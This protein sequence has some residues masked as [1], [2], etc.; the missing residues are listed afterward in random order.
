VGPAPPANV[1]AGIGDTELII[2]WDVPTDTTSVLGYN[3]YIDPPQNGKVPTD[4]A[5]AGTPDAE[6]LVC[7]EGGVFD[8]GVNEAGDAL[9]PIV[10]E[11]GCSYVS[12]GGGGGSSATTPSSCPSTVIVSSA[13]TTSGG[14]EAGATV[15]GGTLPPSDPAYQADQSV[16]GAISNSQAISGLNNGTQY[17]VAVA[18]VDKFH[19]V[20][21]MSAVY[22]ETPQVVN[23]FWKSYRDAGGE[24]GGGFCALQL[25]GAPAGSTSLFLVSIAGLVGWVRSQRSR[26]RRANSPK[27]THN[28]RGR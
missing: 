18:S 21:P 23:V 19:N 8:A 5:A 26:Q 3:L 24:A 4:A 9:P 17:T 16:Q 12:T 15:S 20:G 13:F 6:T 22:C 1:H 14:G 27:G 11:G 7:T 2:H 25:P 10:I 28:R